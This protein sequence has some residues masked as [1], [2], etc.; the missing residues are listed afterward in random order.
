MLDEKTVFDKYIVPFKL[1][2]QFNLKCGYEKSFKL[3]DRQLLPN[4]YL[5]AISKADLDQEK[6][7]VICREMNMPENFLRDFQ[8]NLADANLILLGFEENRNNCVFKIYL[9][10]WDKF[11]KGMRQRT[12][13]T[14]PGLLFLGFKW[15]VLDNTKA[16]I[17]KYTCYPKLTAEGILKRMSALYHSHEDKKSFEIAGKIINLAASRVDPTSFRYL[18][19]GE[20]NNPRKSFDINFYSANL[21]I[22]N[23][24]P[25]LSELGRHYLIPNQEFNHLYR[26]VNTEIFG[27]LSGGIDRD[28]QDFLTV[29][30]E[31]GEKSEN[32]NDA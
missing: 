8:D 24:S 13:K 19:A 2:E 10:F 15:D 1:V 20:E 11:L 17:T 29:Y 32:E 5:L 31:V 12:D 21:R 14:V 26:R 27:H 28:G 23:L 4:R 22:R 3:L 30:Y 16:A 18:E 9:E 25:M 7:E 6:L